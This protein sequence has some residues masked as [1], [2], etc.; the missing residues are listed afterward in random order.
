MARITYVKKA[1]Q[2]Y[3][4]VV[5]RDTE[6]KPV[7]VPVM[8]RVKDRETGEVTEVQKTTKK[9]RPVFRTLSVVDKTK[10][11]KN[12]HCDAGPKCKHDNSEI[13]VGSP[14]KWIAPKSG[15]YGGI[16]R[17]RH[18]D[19]PDW[20]IWEYSSN[21]R[22]DI[23]RA[24]HEADIFGCDSKDDVEQAVHD[25]AETVREVAGQYGESADNIVDG[26]GHETSTSEDLRSQQEALE[27]WADE[28]ESWS[29]TGSDSPDGCGEHETN[30][31]EDEGGECEDCE[32]ERESWLEE[33]RSEADE[34]I[35]QEP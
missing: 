10:P 19:C 2:R 32:A 7:R 3:E 21:K 27:G 31:V 18:G 25:F 1:Q 30:I 12:H 35:N 8:K 28:L 24:Q 14:Y 9:G 6:G 16:K 20:Q 13:E 4:M 5:K 26:F 34:I 15:P 22:A 11:K 17:F 23:W 33:M 29:S